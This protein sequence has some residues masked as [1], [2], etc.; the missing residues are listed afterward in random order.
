MMEHYIGMFGIYEVKNTMSQSYAAR[1]KGKASITFQQ[2]DRLEGLKATKEV[3]FK[4]AEYILSP[5]MS[6]M[7]K[8]H[9]RDH[10]NELYIGVDL[11]ESESQ[12]A[13]FMKDGKLLDERRMKTK[14]LARFL[15]SLPGEKH[16]GME[17]AGFIYPVFDA[18][19][20]AGCDVSVCNPNTIRERAK[21]KIRHDRL[22]A[23]T[24]GDLLR[25]NYFPRSHI[26]DEETRE[27]R[28]LTKERVIY[29]VRRAELKNSIK[30]MLK[31]GG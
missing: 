7:G 14:G 26:P 13:I 21:S 15:S 6:L 2:M 5:I 27:K 10:M 20:K 16:I 18:L 1:S 30:W 8:R 25:T 22:D 19:T 28:L 12:L 31:R 9:I 23:R 3:I 17:S 24:L 4:E 29:G 11:H